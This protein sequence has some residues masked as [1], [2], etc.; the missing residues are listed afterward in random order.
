MSGVADDASGVPGVWNFSEPMSIDTFGDDGDFYVG[1]AYSTHHDM[2]QYMTF[3][4]W[5]HGVTFDNYSITPDSPVGLDCDFDLNDSCNLADIDMLIAEIA[6]GT[7]DA[8]LDINGDGVVD[9]DDRDDWL[10]AAGS[11]NLASGNAYLLGDGNLD[12]VVDVADFNLWNGNKFTSTAAWSQGDFNADGFSDVGDFNIWNGTKFTSSLDTTA[13][14]PE[15]S[16]L[17]WLLP[18]G[19]LAFRRQILRS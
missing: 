18:M 9:L 16:A 15:P 17:F 14:V 2:Q 6:A 7:N 12:G 4:Q 19:L 8:A 11:Q 10:S 3:P 13:A 1:L 5:T